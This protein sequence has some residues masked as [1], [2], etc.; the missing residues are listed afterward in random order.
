M[1]SAFCHAGKGS[2]DGGEHAC[3]CV[4]VVHMCSHLFNVFMAFSGSAQNIK[5]YFS[6]GCAA[7]GGLKVS[8]LRCVWLLYV[9]HTKPKLV[10]RMIN[11]ITHKHG[12]KLK[13][14]SWYA[15]NYGNCLEWR[16]SSRL[17]V[18]DKGY[19]SLGSYKLINSMKMLI[20]LPITTPSINSS[21]LIFTFLNLYQSNNHFMSVL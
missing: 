16:I 9:N 12:Q 3:V 6:A 14:R 13:I 19:L 10:S 7:G 15:T 8:W 4:Y 20:T 2:G 1:F 18:H 11:L 21:T 17:N 5:N